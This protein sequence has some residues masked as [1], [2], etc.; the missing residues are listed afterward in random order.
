MENLIILGASGDIAKHVIDILVDKTEIKLTL[1]LRDMDRLTNTN[2]LN[3]RVI[4]GDVLKYDQLKAAING[5]GYGVCQSF[6]Q[7]GGYGEKHH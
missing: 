6:R 5:Q 4:E 2:L 1:F 3:C 7:P